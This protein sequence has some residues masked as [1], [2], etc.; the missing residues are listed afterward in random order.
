MIDIVSIRSK[1]AEIS[2]IYSN[3]NIDDFDTFVRARVADY[4]INH[5][6]AC[7]DTIY[8]EIDEALHTHITNGTEDD[9]YGSDNPDDK[10][11]NN[12]ADD[13]G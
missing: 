4:F 11:N 6:C 13:D 7:T 1:Y 5:N 12:L 8:A 2:S 3:R 9:F 10:D